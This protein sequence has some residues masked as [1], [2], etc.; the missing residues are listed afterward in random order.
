MTRITLSGP[1][2]VS[3]EICEDKGNQTSYKDIRPQKAGFACS[4]LSKAAGRHVPEDMPAESR[5]ICKQ[6]REPVDFWLSV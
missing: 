4:E 1:L 2:V 5:Y 3:E 6:M